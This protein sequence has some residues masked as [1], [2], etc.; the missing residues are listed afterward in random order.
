MKRIAIWLGG[1]IASLAFIA[2]G[3]IFFC[4]GDSGAPNAVAS[5]TGGGSHV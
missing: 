5:R 1:I 2:A 3:L 4:S